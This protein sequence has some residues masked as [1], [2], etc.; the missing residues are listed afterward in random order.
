MLVKRTAAELAELIGGTCSGDPACEAIGVA[1]IE[2]ASP[3]Q[4]SFIADPKYADKLT[5]SK[6]GIVLY[7]V[8]SD[9]TLPQGCTGIACDDP[10][11]DFSKVVAVFAPPPLV[12][13]PGI[14]S[15]A[16]VAKGAVI[17]ESAHIGANAV[18]DECA[19]VEDG[20]VVGAGCY[21][22]PET[23]IGS[24]SLLYPNVTVRERC[25]IGN[26]VIIHSGTV[27]GADGFGF[28]PGATGHTKIPQV[29][30]VQIDDDVEI[31]ANVCVDRA[32]FGKTWIKQGAKIDNLVQVA[33]NVVVGELCFLVGQCGVAGSSRLGKG[34]VLAGQSGVAGHL[35]IGD[36]AT[37]MAQACVIG[38][39]D[40]GKKVVGFPA[41]E[42][43]EYA[44]SQMQLKRVEKLGKTVKQLQKQVAELTAKLES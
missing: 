2:E 4:V 28:V 22:G 12:F 24:D 40:A 27:I 10:S 15:S 26:R 5:V 23:R 13:S 37:V 39:V 44:R 19:V 30:I 21:L 32:R 41:V 1:S 14:H 35:E 7:P 31:G 29:G 16:V 34:V 6:A 17:A 8:D 11:A 25:I 18:V 3:E 33:H 9:I 38:D 20:S 42:H 36:G 43:R